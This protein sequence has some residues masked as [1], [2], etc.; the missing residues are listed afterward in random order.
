[1]IRAVS[2]STRARARLLSVAAV[3]LVTVFNGACGSPGNRPPQKAE[4]PKPK[5]GLLMDTLDER[6]QR[7]RDLFMT[8]VVTLPEIGAEFRVEGAEAREPFRGEVPQ[9]ILQAPRPPIERAERQ[10]GFGQGRVPGHGIFESDAALGRIAEA[11]R[12]DAA[13]VGEA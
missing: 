10:P 3:V 8:A 11:H 2:A 1:M 13:Q 7:D 4:E 9:R 5:I 12:V 6:W